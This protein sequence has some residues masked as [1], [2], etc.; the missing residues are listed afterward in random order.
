MLQSLYLM[1]E[2]KNHKSQKHS[3]VFSTG[4]LNHSEDEKADTSLFGWTQNGSYL[5]LDSSDFWLIYQAVSSAPRLWARE[6][7]SFSATVQYVLF[8]RSPMFGTCTVYP[9]VL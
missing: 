7:F 4:S 3:S 6:I 8:L 5:A 9:M 2:A 1:C